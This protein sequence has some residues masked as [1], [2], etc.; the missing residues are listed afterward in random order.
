M[1]WKASLT[2]AVIVLI[3]GGA[4][5]V[6]SGGKTKTQTRLIASKT[7]T[8]TVTTQLTNPGPG[9]GTGVGPPQTTTTPAGGASLGPTL[10]AD[11]LTPVL[12]KLSAYQP[13]LGQYGSAN[14]DASS[15]GLQG[16][17]PALQ[18]CNSKIPTPGLAADTATSYVGY[19]SNSPTSYFGSDAASFTGQGAREFVSAAARQALVC[20]W[21]SLPGKQLDDQVVRLTTDQ[22]SPNN[23]MLHDDVILI[24]DKSCVLE[25][26]LAESSGTHSSDADALAVAAARRLALAVNGA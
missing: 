13:L 1:N 20:G 5:G 22:Q 23:D 4:V 9:T 8:K 7:V 14:P 10:S 19:P 11:Q 24:R 25:I 12:V 18:L 3:G 15:Y 26:G 21:R 6:A 17:I 2:G 16:G